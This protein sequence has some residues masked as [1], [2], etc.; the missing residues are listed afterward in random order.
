VSLKFASAD[1]NSMDEAP[2]ELLTASN[3][4]PNREIDPLSISAATMFVVGHPRLLLYPASFSEMD[5]A[6]YGRYALARITVNAAPMLF[7]GINTT[8]WETFVEDRAA[9][10]LNV[11]AYTDGRLPAQSPTPQRWIVAGLGVAIMPVLRRL[12]RR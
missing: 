5:T 9:F 2:W 4:W 12:S 8:D 11:L 1:Y 6:E 10:R 7:E 3:F